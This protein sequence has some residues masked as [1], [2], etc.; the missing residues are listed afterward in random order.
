MR[1]EALLLAGHVTLLAALPAL[2]LPGCAAAMGPGTG[3]GPG[4]RA[5]GPAPAQG[6]YVPGQVIARFRPGVTPERVAALVAPLGLAVERPL[7]LERTYLLRITDGAPVPEA[8]E[9]LGTLAALEYAEPNRLYRLPEPP[10]T[11][12][13]VRPVQPLREP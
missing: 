4:N 1:M 12:Q 7:R 3:D 9:R 8:I 5:A 11:V 10:G 13:P 6:D 2:L